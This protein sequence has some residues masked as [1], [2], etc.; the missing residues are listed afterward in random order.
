VLLDGRYRE[1]GSNNNGAVVATWIAVGV[2]SG[3]IKGKTGTIPQGR[4]LKA[5]TGEDI[6][7]VPGAP[8]PPVPAAATPA[9][10][11]APEAPAAEP[12]AAPAADPAPPPSPP[13]EAPKN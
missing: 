13:A 11:S 6:G 12:A 8:P 9:P 3:F 5:R 4:E 10:A 7:F 2:F 1:E